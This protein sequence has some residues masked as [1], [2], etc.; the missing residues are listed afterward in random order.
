[1]QYHHIVARKLFPAPPS[2]ATPACLAV[3]LLAEAHRPRNSAEHDMSL[4][5]DFLQKQPA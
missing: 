2:F 5:A 3:L 1:M 4:A